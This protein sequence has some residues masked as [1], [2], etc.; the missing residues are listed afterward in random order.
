MRIHRLVFNHITQI[1]K[2]YT[3]LF[4]RL[5]NKCNPVKWTL[6]KGLLITNK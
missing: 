3:Q 5:F 4:D 1:N 6:Q 2:Y